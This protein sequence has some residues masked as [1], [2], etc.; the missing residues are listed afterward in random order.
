MFP[1]VF[2]WD[3]GGSRGVSSHFKSG[4]Y[5]RDL[6]TRFQKVSGAFKMD[7]GNFRGISVGIQSFQGRF[8]EFRKFLRMG[9]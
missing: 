5:E 2:Q 8:K 1:R 7:Y 6:G 9:L 4:S 3:Y